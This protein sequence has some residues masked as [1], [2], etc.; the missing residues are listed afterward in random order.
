[1]VQT[2]LQGGPLCVRE[3]LRGSL[4]RPFTHAFGEGGI[5]HCA[6]RTAHNPQVAWEQAIGIQIVE[7]RKQHPLRQGTCRPED[8]DHAAWL[9]HT[10][11]PSI[12]T[13]DTVIA[14]SATTKFARRPGAIEPISSPSPRN[15][16]GF[17]LAML[18][19]SAR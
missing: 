16:A 11:R 5:A 14:S 9:R 3:M 18:T 13:S 1:M 10:I 6:A 15:A 2:R 7:R 4:A 8:H 17:W 19:A 12:Q